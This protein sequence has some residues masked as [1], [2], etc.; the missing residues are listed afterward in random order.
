MTMSMV[1]QSPTMPSWQCVPGHPVCNV[2]GV[3]K[4]EGPLCDLPRGSWAWVARNDTITAQLDLICSDG[5]KPSFLGS[6][7]F[8]GIGVGAIT[9]GPMSD[10]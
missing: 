6:I 5:W 1:F 3:Q 2:T 10:R 4:E 7:Y 9:F 8:V